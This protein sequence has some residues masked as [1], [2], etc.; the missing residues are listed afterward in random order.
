VFTLGIEELKKEIIAKANENARR[1]DEE[2]ENEARSLLNEAKR[3]GEEIMKQAREEAG[4]T[5]EKEDNE[6]MSSLRLRMKGILSEAKEENSSKVLGDVW[7]MLIQT[8]DRKA[9]EKILERMIEEGVR[10]IGSDAVV[11]VNSEDRKL[12]RKMKG[13]KLADSAIEC[14]GGAIVTTPDGRIRIDNTFEA[15][16]E[17]RKDEMR[18]HIFDLLFKKE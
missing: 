18:K 10:G 3:R 4:R 13:F 11:Y 17:E 8:R 1:I 16:F 12:A 6:R 7:K 14:A 5:L 2:A 15:N 9:Y